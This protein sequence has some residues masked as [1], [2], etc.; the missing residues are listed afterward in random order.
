M[1]PWLVL[2]GAL[3]LRLSG[4]LSW[5]SVKP[6]TIQTRLHVVVPQKPPAEAEQQEKKSRPF[7]G[8]IFDKLRKAVT[9]TEAKDIV[10]TAKKGDIDPV[11]ERQPLDYEKEEAVMKRDINATIEQTFSFS[12][13][14][15]LFHFSPS[16]Q[17]IL[18]EMKIRAKEDMTTV[19]TFFRGENGGI[20][21]DKAVRIVYRGDRDKEEAEEED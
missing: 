5:T 21:A 8:D 13:T 9:R 20:G 1:A 15:Q 3:L 18:R 14:L 17:Q 6:C 2:L 4:T 19:G 7:W 12:P 10:T 11:A 16:L